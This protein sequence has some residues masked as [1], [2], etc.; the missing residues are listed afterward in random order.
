MEN[1]DKLRVSIETNQVLVMSVVTA[2]SDPN[3]IH[4]LLNPYPSATIFAVIVAMAQADTNKVYFAHLRSSLVDVGV[5]SPCQEEQLRPAKTR[6]RPAR[7]RLAV[8]KRGALE[9]RL[10]L[11]GREPL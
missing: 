5:G 7:K 6:Q 3:A 1:I 9:T 11:R 10:D 4:L 8:K 2:K